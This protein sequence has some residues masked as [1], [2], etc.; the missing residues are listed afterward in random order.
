MKSLFPKLAWAMLLTLLTSPL[1]AQIKVYTMN[2]CSRCSY[3]VKYL[4]EN[5]IA[6]TELNTTTNQANNSA[7]WAL[8]ADK[9]SGRITMPVIDN[10]GEVAFS[11]P[12]LDKYLKNLGSKASK[13]TDKPISKKEETPSADE[14]IIYQHANYEGKS[15]RLKVGKYDM[16]QLSIGNDQLSSAKVPETL[17]MVLYEHSNFTGN[18][19]ELSGDFDYIGEDFNDLTSS[20][21]IMR[22][23]D[24]PQPEEHEPEPEPA[25]KPTKVNAKTFKGCATGKENIP[26]EN[27]AFEKKVMEIVN[28]ERKKVGKPAMTWDANL[29]RAARYHAADMA[30]E[31]YFD[32]ASHDVENGVETK[33]CDTF[34]RISKFG[35]GYAENIAMGSTSPEG[36]MN[37]WM[38]SAGHKR[39]ILSDNTTI[40]VGF[41]KGHWVQV[42][43]V[44]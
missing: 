7:M 9:A 42:F 16:Q 27:E 40:G 30:T 1:H 28:A 25:P 37:Q 2:G 38:N 20:I 21:E 31:G 19:M 26:A 32:H 6:F 34:E 22:A 39:N 12:D 15:Q 13:N 44:K 11:I 23:E 43:G 8:L 4:T 17:V 10:N 5:N 29:A 24:A 36:A 14:V 35:K 33:V 18:S 41:Y 3:A